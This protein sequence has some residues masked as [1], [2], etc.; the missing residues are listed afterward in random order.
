M[1][2]LVLTKS[3]R[4]MLFLLCTGVLGVFRK[5]DLC[6][7]QGTEEKLLLRSH[8][9]LPLPDSPVSEAKAS[10][11]SLFSSPLVEQRP[12]S[13]RLPCLASSLSHL[14]LNTVCARERRER[15]R[16]NKHRNERWLSSPKVPHTS[17]ETGVTP[18]P[19]WPP[20]LWQGG[21][22]CRKGAPSSYCHPLPPLPVPFDSSI[23]WSLS[24]AHS[25]Q[26]IQC[27]LDKMCL[28]YKQ[29]K[30]SRMRPGEPPGEPDSPCALPSLL[31]FPL[32]SLPLP[33]SFL[34][35]PSLLPSPP[36]SPPPPLLPS[37]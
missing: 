24:P 2:T 30:K 11:G 18:L 5:R 10:S 34:P 26:Q 7:C 23:T 21:S 36:P 9:Q 27:S 35:P 29:F 25:I 31:P 37:Q 14:L 19:D 17:L 33:P 15:E 8:A 6:P 32:S 1:G 12:H 22:F 3:C 16:E 4:L 20:E 13:C 28:I